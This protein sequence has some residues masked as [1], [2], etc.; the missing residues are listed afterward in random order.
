MWT[1]CEECRR[2]WREYTLATTDH[3]RL[4]NNLQWAAFKCDREAI[5]ILTPQV[6]SAAEKRH[7][8]REAIRGHE[9]QHGRTEH[10]SPTVALGQQVIGIEHITQQR[11]HIK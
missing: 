11:I 7:S 4:G 5:P 2:L 9:T 3:V 6:E 1:L 8:S 10:P